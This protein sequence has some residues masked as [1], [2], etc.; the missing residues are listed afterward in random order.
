MAEHSLYIIYDKRYGSM[1]RPVGERV[2]E[3]DPRW[4]EPRFLERLELPVM[5]WEAPASP[6]NDARAVWF[7][8]PDPQSTEI[9]KHYHNW[10]K[11]YKYPD[12]VINHPMLTYTPKRLWYFVLNQNGIR[13]PHPTPKGWFTKTEFHGFGPTFSVEY[14]ESRNINAINPQADNPNHKVWRIVYFDGQVGKESAYFEETGYWVQSGGA[15]V[16]ELK[17]T[18]KE[19]VEIT[20]KVAEVSGLKYFHIEIIPSPWVGPVVV[21]VN[22]HPFD[23]LEGRLNDVIKEYTVNRIKEWL[24][25]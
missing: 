3:N 4:S 25:D 1:I 12:R 9:I 15:C 11:H 8:L 18:P 24:S 2:R 14:I 10:S 7:A 13:A 20:C 17:E 23:I 21:D 19:L 6:P 16:R 5:L 22:P